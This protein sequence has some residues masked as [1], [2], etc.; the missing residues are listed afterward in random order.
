MKYIEELSELVRGLNN[1]IQ[2]IIIEYI[3]GF[4]NKIKISINIKDYICRNVFINGLTFETF[5][6]RFE[7]GDINL[8]RYSL[9]NR[10]WRKSF[11]PSII[12]IGDSNITVTKIDD[13]H[14]E[15]IDLL[16]DE[17]ECSESWDVVYRS[18]GISGLGNPWRRIHLAA[19]TI[20]SARR[21]QVGRRRAAMHLRMKEGF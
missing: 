16:V 2:C 12:G 17:L 7:E 15:D 10:I 20:Q 8:L 4:L 14:K 3:L 5:P 19:M 9:N 21:G 11:T 18:T 6:E 13:I 1:D